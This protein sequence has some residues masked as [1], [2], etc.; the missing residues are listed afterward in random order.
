MNARPKPTCD[1]LRWETDV[2]GD[3]WPQCMG[4]LGAFYDWE[5]LRERGGCIDDMPYPSLNVEE[6]DNPGQ[7]DEL[8]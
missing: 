6:E 2:G 1:Q 5:K 4:V 7:T 3:I 8:A